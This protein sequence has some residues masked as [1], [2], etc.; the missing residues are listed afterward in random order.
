MS[1]LEENAHFSTIYREDLKTR[2]LVTKGSHT[3]T[4]YL[5]LL[6]SHSFIIFILSFWLLS[7]IQSLLHYSYFLDK[8]NL[9][10][11]LPICSKFTKWSESVSFA[12][13][14]CSS[15]PLWIVKS[16]SFT[17]FS[18]HSWLQDT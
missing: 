3:Q 18:S 15:S 17:C 5:V 13:S 14:S 2:W 11:S 12:S 16:G 7:L 6:L 10:I 8:L 9:S 1:Q 4:S